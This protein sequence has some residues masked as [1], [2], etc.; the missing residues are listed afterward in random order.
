MLDRPAA[1]G[2]VIEVGVAPA[3]GPAVLFA[4]NVNA[5]RKVAVPLLNT[6]QMAYTPGSRVTA[7]SNAIACPNAAVA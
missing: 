7:L 5:D 6:R 3:P 2:K 4:P 1:A